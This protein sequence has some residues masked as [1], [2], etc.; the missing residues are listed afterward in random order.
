MSYEVLEDFKDLKDKNKIYRKG[1]TYPKPVNKKISEAR[2]EE[3]SSA[4][5]KLG[6]PLI[7]KLN[8]K[9]EGFEGKSEVNETSEEQE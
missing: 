7:K 4:N 2:L 6:A 1:D 9:P 3:L 8:E 5:N